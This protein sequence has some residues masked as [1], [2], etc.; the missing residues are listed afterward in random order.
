MLLDGKGTPRGRL[1]AHWMFLAPS[2]LQTFSDAR[3]SE[4]D[5]DAAT[6]D[7]VGKGNKVDVFPLAPP[8]VRELRS[9]RRWQ[10][11]E[12]QRH[13]AMRDALADP[14]KAYVLLT[15]NGKRTHPNSIAKMLRRH[16]VINGVGVTAAE[17]VWDM[18]GGVTSRVSPHVMRRTWATLALND[19]ENPQPIDVV[20]EVLRHS[21]IST[22][23]RHYAPTKSDRARK[24]L[25][26]MSV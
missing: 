3:W 2:R 11:S 17:G 18:P 6:W 26:A 20:S 9:Y 22:T 1:L 24:A 13:P 23:R 21:D 7:L 12:A 14:D 8:L 25:L 16:A 5:L 4:I 19:D 15:R 10:L